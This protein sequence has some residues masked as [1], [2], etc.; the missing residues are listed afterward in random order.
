MFLS[1]VSSLM[2]GFMLQIY[3]KYSKPPNFYT[4]FCYLYIT[5]YIVVAHTPNILT[6]YY[7]YTT[8]C[9]NQEIQGGQVY[10][11]HNSQNTP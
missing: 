4:L 7:F 10:Y 3:R 5:F 9:V 8:K 2:L 1:Y 11:L 6:I